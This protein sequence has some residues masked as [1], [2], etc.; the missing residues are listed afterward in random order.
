MDTIERE[1]WRKKCERYVNHVQSQHE[2][3]PPTILRP[4]PSQ[5][6][7]TR[8]GG[9]TCHHEIR[10]AFLLSSAHG[11]PFAARAKN[12][13]AKGL[14]ITIFLGF[15]GCLAYFLYLLVLR[16]LQFGFTTVRSFKAPLPF[17]T[18]PAVTVC[19]SNILKRTNVENSRFKTTLEKHSGDFLY[20]NDTKFDT[21]L[22][23]V[24]DFTSLLTLL[25]ENDITEPVQFLNQ[26]DRLKDVRKRSFPSR[27]DL[28]RIY[29]DSHDME[30]V[31]WTLDLKESEV[32]ALGHTY[33]ETIAT[34]HSNGRT[35]N[36]RQV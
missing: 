29:A 24:G 4:R 18:F 10:S 22:I 2:D 13:F 14:W 12:P 25:D 34:C 7:T 20:N 9:G 27:E 11:L 23:D 36:T 17:D 5:A 16:Y 28:Y 6:F 19:N 21:P 31:W 1:D 15:C 32:D 8:D 26:L 35:C 3:S 33:G 30:L